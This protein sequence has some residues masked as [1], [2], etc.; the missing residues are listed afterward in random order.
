VA[1]S[2]A[3]GR[4]GKTVGQEKTASQVVAAKALHQA[5]FFPKTLVLVISRS[6][7]QSGELFR[8]VLDGYWAVDRP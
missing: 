5:L 1:N 8:Y 6:Q 2:K 7:P 3:I 4:P